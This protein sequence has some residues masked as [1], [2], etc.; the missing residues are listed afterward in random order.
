MEWSYYGRLSGNKPRIGV[1][2]FMLDQHVKKMVS[3][4]IT[5][6]KEELENI[7]SEFKKDS[8]AEI[9]TLRTKISRLEMRIDSLKKSKNLIEDYIEE[10]IE[11][12]VEED[13][14]AA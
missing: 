1:I 7:L 14:L 3:K 4:T 13:N 8:L 9:K 2:Y 12:K 10:N 11:E 6:Y 5:D